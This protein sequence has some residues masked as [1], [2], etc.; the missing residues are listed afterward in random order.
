[1]ILAAAGVLLAMGGADLHLRRQV[2]ERSKPA[3][4]VTDLTDAA[5]CS[6]GTKPGVHPCISRLL[7]KAVAPAREA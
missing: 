5:L 6:K 7:K 4:W 1:V 2:V 3:T